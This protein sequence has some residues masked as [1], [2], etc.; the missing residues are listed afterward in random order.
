[1]KNVLKMIA[2]LLIS[3]LIYL[4]SAPTIISRHK[5]TVRGTWLCVAQGCVWHTACVAH[6]CVWHTAARG[7]R[8]RVA[9]D[10]ACRA[11]IVDA[12]I[13]VIISL[14]I[15]IL[16]IINDIQYIYFNS[17]YP[18][19]SPDDEGG[20]TAPL[21]NLTF[22]SFRFNRFQDQPNCKRDTVYRTEHKMVQYDILTI[23]H[24]LIDFAQNAPWVVQF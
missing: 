6:G 22:N 16:I 17:T 11:I 12:D 10:C 18:S 4:V 2:I 5:V 24:I 8:L 1:M 23:I 14:T 13:R 20:P 7:T 9:Q 19:C 3:L 21:S 15:N